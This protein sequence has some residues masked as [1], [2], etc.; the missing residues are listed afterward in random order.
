MA[1]GFK[2]LDAAEENQKKPKF[3]AFNP[4]ELVCLTNNASEEISSVYYINSRIKFLNLKESEKEKR[5]ERI[6]REEF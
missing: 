6:V 1:K 5:P 2:D 3:L 4:E